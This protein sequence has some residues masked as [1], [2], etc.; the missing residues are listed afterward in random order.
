MSAKANS[1]LAAPASI[2][3]ERGLSHGLA[4]R[5]AGRFGDRGARE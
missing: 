5:D 4:E 3:V 1:L 2:A